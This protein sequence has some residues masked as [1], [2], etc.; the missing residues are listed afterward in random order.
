[1]DLESLWIDFNCPSCG[2][3]DEI[4]MIDVRLESEI[5]CHNCKKCIKLRDSDA[6]VD[7]SIK[8]ID[9]AISDIKKIFKKLR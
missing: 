6:S 4:Q 3:A 1:M 9:R 8:Q 2:Y 7:S 5:W